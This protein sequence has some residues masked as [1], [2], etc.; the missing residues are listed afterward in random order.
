MSSLGTDSLKRA[1]EAVYRAHEL[2]LKQQRQWGKNNVYQ[3]S[4]PPFIVQTGVG[5]DGLINKAGIHSLTNIPSHTAA[6]ER[7]TVTRT[8]RLR[9]EYIGSVV[10]GSARRTTPSSLLPCLVTTTAPQ[11]HSESSGSFFFPWLATKCHTSDSNLSSTLSSLQHC[12]TPCN[13]LSPSFMTVGSSTVAIQNMAH[14][15]RLAKS[16]S[17][18][19]KIDLDSYNIT[20]LHQTAAKFFGTCRLPQSR[21][22][23]EIL[24]VRNLS[25]MT[26]ASNQEL[27]KH[28][29]FAE[30]D[31]EETSVD[32][33]TLQ[34]FRALGYSL[35]TRA[36]RAR[37]GLRLGICGE[38]RYAKTDICL[39]DSS[40]NDLMLLVQED[41]RFRDSPTTRAMKREEAE[42]Q[43]FAEAIA[44]FTWNNN[45]Q[46]ESGQRPLDSQVHAS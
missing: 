38:W 36:V 22:D 1:K 17:A 35:S 41:K 21:V 37:K 14:I 5:R 9:M 6:K 39:L 24:D 2:V 13:F 3:R 11:L 33:F 34:L 15:T 28:L 12:G 40:K 7:L 25:D 46:C 31:T 43:L 29:D 45:R 19:N 16:A 26:V 18:W 8:V 20:I 32:D 30:S 42:V 10:Y 44:A 27:L 23:A 4:I